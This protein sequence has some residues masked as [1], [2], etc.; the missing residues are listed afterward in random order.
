MASVYP[1]GAMIPLF[2]LRNIGNQLV[3]GLAV[4]VRVLNARDGTVL[5]ASIPVPEVTPGIYSLLWN[6][7]I[8]SFTECLEIYTVAG[9]Q[10]INSFTVADLSSGGGGA[11]TLPTCS[12]IE[13]EVRTQTLEAVIK[14]PEIQAA[15][16]AL[17]LEG[18]VL[19]N[20]TQGGV[21]KPSETMGEVLPNDL[22]GELDC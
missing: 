17:G 11:I 21:E 1:I 19:D 14:I 12:T 3:T 15:L 16:D 5:L 10:F 18:E 13:A 22:S 8:S 2:Y 9:V 4:S 7:M 6:N 20:E